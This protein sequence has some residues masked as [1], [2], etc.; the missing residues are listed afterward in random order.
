MNWGKILGENEEQVRMV[1][2]TLVATYSKFL[3]KCCMQMKISIETTPRSINRPTMT[4]VD[5]YLLHSPVA[6]PRYSENPQDDVI[7]MADAFLTASP[8]FLKICLVV[9]YL[10]ISRLITLCF[11]N[12]KL[13]HSYN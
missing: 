13:K 6:V 2:L 9:D 10:T 5:S 3:S 1:N 7:A 8:I 4:C 11:R 12:P